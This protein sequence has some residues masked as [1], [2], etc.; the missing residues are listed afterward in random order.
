MSDFKIIKRVRDSFFTHLSIALAKKLHK[1]KNIGGVTNKLVNSSIFGF[2]L[3]CN[4][5]S[6]RLK[7]FYFTTHVILTKGVLMGKKRPH[8]RPLFEPGEYVSPVSFAL[9]KVLDRVAERMMDTMDQEN[10]NKKNAKTKR[11]AKL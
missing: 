1:N 11:R 8:K 5:Y 7:I 2:R 4:Y 9:D 3:L 10:E 6:V